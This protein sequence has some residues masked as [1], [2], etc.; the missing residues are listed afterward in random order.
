M[1]LT[2]KYN[3]VT[4]EDAEKVFEPR[5]PPNEDEIN[6]EGH[7]EQPDE[8]KQTNSEL[9]VKDPEMGGDVPES[10]EENVAP[11]E[12]SESLMTTSSSDQDSGL[13]S[14]SIATSPTADDSDEEE[15]GEFKSKGYDDLSDM[16]LFTSEDDDEVFLDEKKNVNPPSL[17]LEEEKLKKKFAVENV[18]EFNDCEIISSDEEWQ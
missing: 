17:K 15:E 10:S 18:I 7:Q 6:S 8:L 5:P 1:F 16:D 4:L 14:H 2:K 9:V 11:K 3:L 13:A 12:E